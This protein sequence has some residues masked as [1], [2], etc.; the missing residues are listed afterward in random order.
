MAGLVPDMRLAKPIF[1]DDG[2]VL[3][4]EDVMLTDSYIHRL[5]KM[6]LTYVY[7]EDKDTYDISALDTVPMEVQQHVMG[8]IKR[9]CD[10][11]SDPARL[12]QVVNSGELGRQFTN[13]FQLLF[14]YLRGSNTFGLNMGA[15]YSQDAYLYK[16]CM[17]VG[18]MASV[19]GIANGYDEEVIK[20]LGIGAM[21]HDIGKLQIDK[22]I[23]D[24]PGKLTDEERNE[25]ERH[26]R[27]GYD[28]LIK[29]VELSATSAHCALQHHEK[30]DGS[31]Y[32][33]R[34]RGQEIHEF[35]RLLAVP[36][37]YDALTSNRVYRKAFL[38]HEAMEFLYSNVGNHFDK[39][40]VDLFIHHVNIY[41]NGLTVQLSN[42]AK[43]VVAR[44][45]EGNLQRPVILVL[46]EEGAP[47]T[48]HELNLAE[49]LNVV[50]TGCDV[51]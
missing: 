50:I 4:Q 51:L 22:A 44:S 11:M 2:R 28:M 47:V 6:S 26:C 48:P 38:P 23:L 13:L 5:K 1:A 27:L 32:P 15:I 14:D 3:L 9:L 40:W 37:V 19:L 30:Y 34:L 7:I 20:N 35:G 46:E 8:E 24:K 29:Q 33:Q 31:G 25:V 17:N 36:D 18:I 16:H 43:G 41:P 12:I 10:K 21:L 45:N 39:Q 42:G 49:Q